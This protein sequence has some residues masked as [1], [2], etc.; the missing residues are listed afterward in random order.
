MKKHFFTGSLLIAASLILVSCC[1]IFSNNKELKAENSGE[2]FK[3]KPG[4]TITILLKS[5]PTTGYNWSVQQNDNNIIKLVNS[6]YNSDSK[7]I[8]A[9]GNQ[10]YTFKLLNP[11]KT[12]LKLVYKRAWEKVPPIR[13]FNLNVIA[14]K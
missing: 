3:G 2:T 5:N 14:K 10:K 11:G 4:D 13:T 7:L 6:K 1:C 8:G 9:G 12:E